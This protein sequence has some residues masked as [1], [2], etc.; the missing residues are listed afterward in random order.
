MVMLK[1]LAS[2]SRA[3]FIHWSNQ[4]EENELTYV[5]A[6]IS[7]AGKLSA[8]RLEGS[9]NKEGADLYEAATAVLDEAEPTWV[10]VHT[11][12]LQLRLFCL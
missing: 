3:H 11:R 4:Y 8:Y 9:I 1:S 10:R 2:F 12:L 6:D 7:L 5:S